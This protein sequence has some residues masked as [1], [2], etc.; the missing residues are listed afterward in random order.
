MKNLLTVCLFPNSSVSH[1][2]GRIKKHIMQAEKSMKYINMVYF[3][4]LN[5][6]GGNAKQPLTGNG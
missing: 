2:D 1:P 6:R 5:K 4:P 3:R